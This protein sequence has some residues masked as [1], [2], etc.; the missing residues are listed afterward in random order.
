[1]LENLVRLPK[2][3]KPYPSKVRQFERPPR[4]AS[5]SLSLSMNRQIC[6]LSIVLLSFN[7]RFVIHDLRQISLNALPSQFIFETVKRLSS[8]A[9]TV[10]GCTR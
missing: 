5:L 2:N 4:Y 10:R 3:Q 9:I 8:L 7:I 1:M 6:D